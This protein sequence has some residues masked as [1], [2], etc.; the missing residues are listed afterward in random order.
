MKLLEPSLA[1]RGENIM[2]ASGYTGGLATAFFTF[3]IAIISVAAPQTLH[4]Q[5]YEK[6]QNLVFYPT[7]LPLHEHQ[8]ARGAERQGS[9]MLALAE[10]L[11]GSDALL[12]F[13]GTAIDSYQ[14]SILELQASEGPFAPAL[15]QNL[16]S[17]GLLYQQDQ[18]HSEAIETLERA[19]A[20][21]RVN[22]GLYSPE[23]ISL[24]EHLI[25]SLR[26]TGQL[27]E[28]EDKYQYLVNLHQHY[29]GASAPQTATA[30]QGLG[31]WKL[32]SF[33][34]SLEQPDSGQM[35]A[36][37]EANGLFTNYQVF[38]TRF[39]ELYQAQATFVDAIRVLIENAAF[40][41]PALF[42]LEQDLIRTFFINAN[43]E[44]VINNPRNYA[45]ADESSLSKLKKRSND[46]ALPVDYSKGEDAY[47]RMIGYLKQNPDASMQ[48]IA[49]VMLG[50]ADWHLMFGKYARAEQQ[51]KQ[52]VKLMI[53][54]EISANEQQTLLAP[55]VPVTL[56]VF[57]DSAISGKPL[58]DA[59]AYMG[60]VDVAM[61]INRYGRVG[62]IEVL[63]SSEG[64]VGIIKE[65]LV[66]LVRNAQF[67]PTPGRSTSTGVRYYYTY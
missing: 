58:D 60:Y 11:R 36:A 65:R 3:T 33:H 12:S 20:I 4:A 49:D 52:L 37:R 23:Q 10:D 48:Q 51:Y 34:H 41:E 35:L 27:S 26:A 7:P 16:L 14:Q 31:Q 21:S 47:R 67:R 6:L 46:M 53:K 1:V 42:E 13:Q 44:L 39:D 66:N 57:L 9:F 43:R 63:G 50:L 28:L 54:A 62:R 15:V 59:S 25:E 61:D 19:A 8:A 30:L 40:T 45:I 29:Y 55:A 22:N 18:R 2:L 24:T 64:T 32:E 5:T 17:L 56:P 38:N